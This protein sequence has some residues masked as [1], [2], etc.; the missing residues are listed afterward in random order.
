MAV[1]FVCVLDYDDDDDDDDIMIDLVLKIFSFLSGQGYLRV[2]ARRISSPPSILSSTDSML[3][4]FFRLIFL[5]SIPATA[6]SLT[7]H[8]LFINKYYH[9][10]KQRTTNNNNGVI[11]LEQ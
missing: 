5:A 2:M 4:F 1:E 6:F 10:N 9:S 7:I 3:A 8:H 11:R